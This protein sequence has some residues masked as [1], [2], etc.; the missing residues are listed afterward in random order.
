MNSRQVCLK[1]KL[2]Y[3]Y[4][5]FHKGLLI[6]CLIHNMAKTSQHVWTV[7]TLEYF[8]YLYGRLLRV[9][10]SGILAVYMLARFSK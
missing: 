4:G 5:G 3:K 2:H 7:Y 8:L 1:K 6:Q 9:K 10:K